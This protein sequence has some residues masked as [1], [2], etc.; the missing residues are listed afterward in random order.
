MSAGEASGDQHAAAVA[1]E[2]RER[3]PDVRLFGLGG[4]HMKAAG[5]E[6]LAGLDQLAVMGFSG[7][8]ARIPFFVRLSRR[9]RALWARE[10]VRLVIPVDYPGLNLRMATWAH[11]GGRRVLYF[12]APQ[13][14]AWKEGRA[15][16][17][18]AVCDRVLTVLPFETEVLEPHG[19]EATFVGHPALDHLAA[20]SDRAVGSPSETRIVGIFPGSRA[21]EV[22]LMLP[23]FARAATLLA[24][25]HADLDFLVA[26]A[27]TLPQELYEGFDLRLASADE[28]RRRAA[29]AM[30]KSGTIT[31][32]LAL[33]GVPM[34]IGYRTTRFTY[35]IARRLLTLSS[36]GLVNLV[37]GEP[38]VPELIQDRFTPEAMARAIEPL[39]V[40]D[41]PA[42]VNMRLG[43][44]E[45]RARLGT[46]GC[47]A[48]VADH[49]VELL[50]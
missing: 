15:K 17:L 49:A 40:M 1:R 5:V 26:R 13:V 20:E 42:R 46:P 48:R 21:Q 36:I 30:T 18:A 44:E 45:V 2:L 28:T 4:P 27:E 16:R 35:A 47:A 32:E 39:L 10:D 7:I 14:W 50:T 9:I 11:T 8:L 41:G 38:F 33:S 19:V 25:R 37:A 34:V 22:R 29:V 43:Y 12:I 3:L 23:I 24:A 31:L 6:L